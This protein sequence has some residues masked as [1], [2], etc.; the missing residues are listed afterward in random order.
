[1]QMRPAGH[2][3]WMRADIRRWRWSKGWQYLIETLLLSFNGCQ[4]E[5]ECLGRDGQLRTRSPACPKKQ[6]NKR[7]HQT[8]AAVHPPQKK[9]R[10]MCK[11]KKRKEGTVA[12]TWKKAQGSQANLASRRLVEPQLGWHCTNSDGRHWF[13]FLS[14]VFRL[15]SALLL[16]LLLFLKRRHYRPGPLRLILLGK[17]RRFYGRPTGRASSKMY[18]YFV[19]L[20]K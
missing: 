4:T 9:R 3:F 8:A 16:P 15:L 2:Y 12:S 18:Q 7:R 19:N 20:W 17:P 5:A 1:M 10:E 14:F 6:R 11:D 13:S